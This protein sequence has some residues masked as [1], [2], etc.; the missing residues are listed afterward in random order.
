MMELFILHSGGQC[1]SYFWQLG[2]WRAKMVRGVSFP[3]GTPK[4][5]CTF[6][7]IFLAV[8]RGFESCRE[9]LWSVC[10]G[11]PVP[12]RP[13]CHRT[14]TL[15]CAGPCFHASGGRGR[16]AV[17]SSQHTNSAE[18]TLGSPAHTR[19]KG[20]LTPDPT[21]RAAAFLVGSWT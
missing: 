21:D 18:C 12:G 4:S 14:I 19:G 11:F 9:A 2:S 15:G 16:P 1:C 5:G 20:D 10:N 7:K 13:P 17:A 6:S 8:A 3:R